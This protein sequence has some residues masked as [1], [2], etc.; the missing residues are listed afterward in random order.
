MLAELELDVA[1][2]KLYLSKYLSLTG[3]AAYPL[4]LGEA[5]EDGDDDSLAAALR[6]AG[7]FVDTYEK[8]KPKG[9]YTTATVPHTA[10]ETLA[11]GEFNRFYLR[12]VCRRLIAAGS[13]SVEVYRARASA[14]PRAE[15]EAMIGTLLDPQTLL[16]DLRDN[17]FVDNALHLP[18]GPNSGLSGRMAG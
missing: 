9:G 2:E 16:G 11:E 13:G 3:R 14:V 5:I 4:L 10:P 8:R 18:P 17:T 7:V 6:A 12:G 15:S 1:E